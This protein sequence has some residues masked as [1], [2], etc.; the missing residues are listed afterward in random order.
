VLAAT[1]S[2]LS[3]MIKTFVSTLFVLTALTA[4]SHNPPKRVSQL[5]LNKDT[6]EKK[7]QESIYAS[8][9]SFVLADTIFTQPERERRFDIWW[10]TE[11]ERKDFRQLW[12]RLSKQLAKK[13]FREMKQLFLDSVGFCGN[14]FHKAQ[15]PDECLAEIFESKLINLVSDTSHQIF[16]N[17]EYVENGLFDNAGTLKD[18]HGHY[19]SINVQIRERLGCWYCKIFE[20]G[21]VLTDKGYKITGMGWHGRDCCR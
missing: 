14:V 15:V 8:D 6:V 2:A 10:Q 16:F 5:S 7:H 3:F 13:D 19:K 4:C 21:F 20:I 17:V 11:K 1:S 12:E 9:S 18:Q